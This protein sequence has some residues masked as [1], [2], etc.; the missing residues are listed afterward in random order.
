MAEILQVLN[1]RCGLRLHR[2]SLDASLKRVESG[3]EKVRPRWSNQIRLYRLTADGE[4]EA[5]MY[6][7]VAETPVPTAAETA[8]LAATPLFLESEPN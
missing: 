5:Q 8:Q 6:L 4:R 1:G 7:N 3:F 2:S